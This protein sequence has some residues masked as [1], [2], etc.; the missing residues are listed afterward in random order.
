MLLGNMTKNH[1]KRS[2]NILMMRKNLKLER[3]ERKKEW[4]KKGNVQMILR[5]RVEAV[6]SRD[7]SEV[8][9]KEPGKVVEEDN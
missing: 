3:V 4:L 9:G 5:K 1:H 8:V 2:L 7:L 6:I